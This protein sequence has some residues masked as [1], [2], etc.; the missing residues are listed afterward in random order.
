MKYAILCLLKGDV[1]SYQHDLVNDIYEKFDLSETKE[2]DLPTHFTLKYS[3]QTDDI[4][5]I[6]T[7]IGAFCKKHNKTSIDVGGF[8]SFPPKV[9][10]IDVKLSKQAKVVF[11]DFISELRKVKW[12]TWDKYDGEGL[13][14]HSTIAEECDHK[15]YSVLRFINN[16]EKHFDCWFDNIT[17]LKKIGN[18]GKLDM[19]EVYKSFYM[20]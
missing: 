9:I 7:L 17:I 3:F 12:M 15:F 20:R 6:E 1:E 16:K 4:K 2:Q 10:F 19:W 5:E 13:H 14:I 8:S 18:K 11:L